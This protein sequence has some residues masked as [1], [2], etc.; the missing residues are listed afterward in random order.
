M[1]STLSSDKMA[2]PVYL[3]IGNLSEVKRRSV[4]TNK[5]LLLCLLPKCPKEPTAHTNRFAYHESI[6]RILRALEKLAK[7]GIEVYCADGRTC[8]TFSRIALFVANYP[9]LCIITVVENDWCPWCE[10]WPDDISGFA[11]RPRHCCPQRYFHLSIIV[12]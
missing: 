3:T 11:R 12:A 8:H 6:A 7:S 2:C 4:R 10:T 5:L 1:L 9:E